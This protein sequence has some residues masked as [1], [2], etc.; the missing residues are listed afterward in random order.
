MLNKYIFFY[1]VLLYSN[2][3]IRIM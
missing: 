1:R 2:L 3:E